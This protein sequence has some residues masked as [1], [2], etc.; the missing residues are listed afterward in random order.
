MQIA[1]RVGELPTCVG[2][3][4][5]CDAKVRAVIEDRHGAVLG[6][7]PLEPTVNPRLRLVIEQRDQGCRY[8]GCSQRRWVQVHH[9]TH[10][11]DGGLTISS[12]LASS[13]ANLS[14]HGTPAMGKRM[15]TR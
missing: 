2:L 15:V 14:R 13:K 1:R 6:I 7:S 8:P 11:E 4:L 3:F 5:C 10:C 12:N 9:L